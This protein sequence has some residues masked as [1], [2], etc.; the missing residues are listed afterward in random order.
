MGTATA[1]PWSTMA[2]RQPSTSPPVSLTSP[3]SRRLTLQ[4]VSWA[5]GKNE[6]GCWGRVDAPKPATLPGLLALLPLHNVTKASDTCDPALSLPA[7][8]PG[9]DPVWNV[10][11]PGYTSYLSQALLKG[12]GPTRAN[13]HCWVY[14]RLTW[15]EGPGLDVV[16]SGWGSGWL[17]GAN[18][19]SAPETGT[20]T[21]LARTGVESGRRPGNWPGEEGRPPLPVT[22]T[23]PASILRGRSRD[24]S[25]YSWL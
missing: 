25:N 17:C 9:G 8:L 15:R 6:E 3:S 20:R 12:F 1:S 2:S 19:E 24:C 13:L 10:T 16:K 4:L 18:P 22:V 5:V 23:Y 11:I 21:R 7:I 14:A